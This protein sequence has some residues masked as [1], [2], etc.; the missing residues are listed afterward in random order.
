MTAAQVTGVQIGLNR[1]LTLRNMSQADLSRATCIDQGRIS[2][3]CTGRRLPSL[4]NC[5]KLAEALDATLD[6]VTGRRW[7][8]DETV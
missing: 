7:A 8:D 1:L 3:W 6:E 4:T 5:I 2:L